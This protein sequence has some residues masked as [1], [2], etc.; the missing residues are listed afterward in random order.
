MAA[1]GPHADR[2]RP[3]RGRPYDDHRRSTSRLAAAIP[4]TVT[5]VTPAAGANDVGSTQRPKVTFS[6]PIL[7][8]T[9]NSD[10]FFA[11]D[12]TGAKLPANIVVTDDGTA[13]WLFFYQPDAGRLDH[14]RHGGWRD[15]P[16]GRRLPAGRRRHRRRRAASSRSASRTVSLA[17]LPGTSL[18]G[19]LA[20]PGPDLRP[21]TID[22]VR[23]GP[24]GVLMTGDDVYLNPIA[25]VRVYILGQESQAVFTDAQGRFTLPSVPSGNVKLVLDGMTATNAPA[26]CYFPEMV[27]DL[28]IEPGK[29]NTVMGS[30]GTPRADGRIGRDPG[31]L[32]AAA[33]VGDP[34]DRQQHRADHDRRVRRTPPRT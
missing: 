6:R 4:L 2:D 13:A 22:D 1:G 32:P 33:E 14:H 27:M 3:R 23:R 7:T 19:I 29:V 34:A 10:N 16:R 24:D 17:S 21:N 20:D 8:S 12:T 28:T 25:N 18:T 31:R 26:G 9:L 5:E 30:M 11:T 15:H